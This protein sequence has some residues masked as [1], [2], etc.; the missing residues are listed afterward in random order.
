MNI[1][2]RATILVSLIAITITS[3]W[4]LNRLVGARSKP[5][6]SG[7]HAPDYYMEDFTTVSMKE[8]GTPKNKLYAVYM[9]HYP[10]DDSTELLKPKMEFF[11]TD[12][13]PLYI[14]AN[15]G[16]VTADNDI[17]LLTGDVIVWEVDTLGE[18]TLQVN[19]GKARILVNQNYAET[20]DFAT[21][22][23]RKTTITGVGLRTYYNDSRFE[24]LSNV[25]TTIQT[26]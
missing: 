18:R 12:K 11:R 5:E 21:I 10:E 2:K 14:S 1:S 22:V 6:T 13:P 7:H 19:T 3:T 24:V 20:D 17:V 4:L 8:D 23:H 9:A 26:K 15:K 16:W 25:R